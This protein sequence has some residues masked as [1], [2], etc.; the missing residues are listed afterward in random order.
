VKPPPTIAR[1]AVSWAASAGS[2]SGASGWS[3]QNGVGA[4]CASDFATAAGSGLAV[5]LRG[6]DIGLT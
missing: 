1:S 6:T 4:A 2:G 5:L 3:S